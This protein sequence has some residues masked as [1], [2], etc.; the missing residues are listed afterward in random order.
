MDLC[1][2]G[3]SLFYIAN[4]RS[5]RATQCF[6]GLW[7]PGMGCG[8]PESESLGTQNDS[9]QYVND[10][11]KTQKQ[12]RGNERKTRKTKDL[13]WS[14]KR[15]C[16]DISVQTIPMGKVNRKPNAALV[17]ELMTGFT[18]KQQSTEDG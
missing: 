1:E 15:K 13:F 16:A 3:A 6:S 17:S 8:L 10:F 9:E 5:A 4:S 2:F 12:L 7:G 11:Y 14:R 18:P